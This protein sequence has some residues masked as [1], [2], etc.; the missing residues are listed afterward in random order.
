MPTRH[1]Y[2]SVDDLR[3]YLAGTS[4]ASNWTDDGGIIERILAASSERIDNY[5]GM[6]SFGPVIETRAYDSGSGRE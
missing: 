1:T 2:A 5:V 4:Y 6:Y 3:E